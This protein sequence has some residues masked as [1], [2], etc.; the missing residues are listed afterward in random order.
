[1][2][3]QIAVPLIGQSNN[4]LA[5]LRVQI[6]AATMSQ[7]AVADF[8]AA[9]RKA[10]D[11][12]EAVGGDG[13]EVQFRMNCDAVATASVAYTDRLLIVLGLAKHAPNP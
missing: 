9:I 13:T 4:M 8:S 6:A 10:V 7:L 1:M 12:D 5:G 2:D 11:K 3:Q